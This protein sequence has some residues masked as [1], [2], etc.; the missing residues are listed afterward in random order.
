MDEDAFARAS[1]SGQGAAHGDTRPVCVTTRR[2]L[3]QPFM[4]PPVGAPHVASVSSG[5][6]A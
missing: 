3:L 4:S 2:V 6:A 5:P 1:R